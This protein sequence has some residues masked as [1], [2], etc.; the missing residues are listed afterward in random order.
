MDTIAR[1]FVGDDGIRMTAPVSEAQRSIIDLTNA[2]AR[3]TPHVP[4]PAWI[5]EHQARYP[6]DPDTSGR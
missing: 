1:E 4:L 2:M 5:I 3:S 6:V